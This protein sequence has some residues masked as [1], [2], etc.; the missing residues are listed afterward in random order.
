M[1]NIISKNKKE[2]VSSM[3]ILKI[4]KSVLFIKTIGITFDK[5]V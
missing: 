3:Y 5:K 4:A 2:M 1:L